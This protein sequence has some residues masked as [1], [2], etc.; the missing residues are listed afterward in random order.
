[1]CASVPVHWHE[2]PQA[3]LLCTQLSF[4]LIF[5]CYCP[6]PLST[7]KPPRS[8]GGSHFSLRASFER[9]LQF[10]FSCHGTNIHPDFSRGDHLSVLPTL[11]LSM[12]FDPAGHVVLVKTLFPSLS[13]PWVFSCF[14]L[15]AYLAL[16]QKG[17]VAYGKTKNSEV[18][19]SWI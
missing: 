14:L 7:P 19:K 1:M 15:T 18:R 10:N 9:L 16:Y 6:F 3:H 12:V 17:R 11:S 4:G 5:S 13:Q 8:P 2:H